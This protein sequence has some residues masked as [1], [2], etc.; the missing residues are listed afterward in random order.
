[1]LAINFSN[2]VAEGGEGQQ[3][4]IVSRTTLDSRVF[5]NVRLKQ[6]E[7]RDIALNHVVLV[8]S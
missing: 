4:C 8:I 3:T 7:A 2:F 1:M 5:N 6:R